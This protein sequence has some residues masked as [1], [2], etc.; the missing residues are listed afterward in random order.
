MLNSYSD[1]YTWGEVNINTYNPNGGELV[2]ISLMQNLLLREAKKAESIA[3]DM[4][5][6]NKNQVKLFKSLFVNVELLFKWQSSF[7]ANAYE[8]FTAIY[9]HFMFVSHICSFTS[10]NNLWTPCLEIQISLSLLTPISFEIVHGCVCTI[11][12]HL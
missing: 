3:K 6:F 9:I 1:E 11:L 5:Y 12:S 10:N 4:D 2:M 7:F 8:I